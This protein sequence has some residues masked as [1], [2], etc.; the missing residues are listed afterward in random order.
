VPTRSAIRA[1]LQWLSLLPVVQDISVDLSE[2]WHP[3]KCGEI[4]VICGVLPRRRDVP[5]T[6]HLLGHPAAPAPFLLL[7]IVHPEYIA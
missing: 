3:G 4:S 5:I 2:T 7:T 6:P 1:E